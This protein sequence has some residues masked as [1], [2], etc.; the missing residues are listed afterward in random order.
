MS[1]RP[2]R[3]CLPVGGALLGLL[4]LVGCKR[5]AEPL[6]G[7]ASEPAAAINQLAQHLRANDLEAYA[8]A[9]VPPAQYQQL[10]QAWANGDSRW[11]LTDLPLDD[12]LP[13][14]LATLAERDAEAKLMR[15]FRAQFAGQ[16]AS[17]RQAA[18][19]LGLFGMQYLSTQGDYT[20]QERAHYVQ[21]VKAM[22]D[23]ATA[24]PLADA[25][26]AKAALPVLTSA[27]RATGLHSDDDFQRAGMTASLQR[28]GP[29]Q[30]ALKQVWASYGLSWDQALETLRTGL[31]E[32]RGDD[33]TV[34]VQYTLA[35]SAVDI[36]VALRRID[37]HWYPRQML[38]DVDAVLAAAASAQAAREPV[39]APSLPD[40]ENTEPAAAKTPAGDL[41]QPAKP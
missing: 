30:A 26:L 31:V 23:W 36:E 1:Y 15:A 37:G 24:A 2:N 34:R 4:L 27:A 9:A 6:P 13:S 38:Q 16:S 7:A 21:L 8:R 14:L 25:K 11:P 5:Q 33:A 39:A 35:G 29:M 41:K 32:Q 22:S 3:W 18:H 12:K 20:D 10:E 19:S 28:L 17:L 40:T